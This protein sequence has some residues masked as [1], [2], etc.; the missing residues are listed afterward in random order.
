MRTRL[1]VTLPVLLPDMA[2]SQ[3]VIASRPAQTRFCP[4]YER[5]EIS[6]GDIMLL[7]NTGVV[8]HS[9]TAS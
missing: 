6:Y 1:N 3:R 7:R 2:L 9:D 4:P 5:V 8:L